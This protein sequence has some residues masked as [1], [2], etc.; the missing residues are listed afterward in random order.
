M[1]RTFVSL[2]VCTLLALTGSL[3]GCVVVK[4]ERRS[5]SSQRAGLSSNSGRR[6]CH[7]SQYWDGETCRHKGKG[8]GARKHDGR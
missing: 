1:K 4:E 6:E 8:R 7:P 5:T 3:S 2:T